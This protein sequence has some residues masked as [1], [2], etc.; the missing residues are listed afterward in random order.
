MPTLKLPSVTVCAASSV[1]IN[2]TIDALLVCADQI[3]FAECLFFTDA[4][5]LPPDPIRTIPVAR[6]ASGADYSDFIL[7]R[8]I[9]HVR[10]THC[11]IVQWDGFVLDAGRWD[12][13]F[14]DYD[15]IGAPWP[16]F[17]DAGNV[18]NGGFSLRSVRLLQA[19]QDPRFRDGHPEDV[20]ICRSNRRLLEEEYGIRFADRSVAEKFAFERTPPRPSFGF[21]GVFN[22]AP[23]FG[24]ARMEALYASLD[25]RSSVFRDY[26]RLLRQLAWRSGGTR[27]MGQLSWD[28]FRAM[29]PD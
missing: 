24:V 20:A 10:T 8:L 4:N 12:A 2:A 17:P 5:V 21:H 18:G 27:L 6:L 7:H 3:D 15:Y 23:L 28:R 9:N 22:I 19:C 1:N 11:L 25:E 26:W 13:R 14:L 29:L 16:Q